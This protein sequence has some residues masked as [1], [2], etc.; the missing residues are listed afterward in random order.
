[1]AT[2][3][4]LYVSARSNGSITIETFTPLLAKGFLLALGLFLAG[5]YIMPHLTKMF[6]ASQELLYMFGL[7]WGFGIASLFHLAGFSIE[8][9]ALFA[10]V[11]LAHLP[12]A[13]EITT[14]LKPLRDFFVFLFF[15]EL[16]QKLG[17]SNIATAIVPAVV[18]S[19]IIMVTKPLLTLVSLGVLGY[20]KQTGF[21]AAVH[22]SQ[23][24]EFS[25]IL[26]VLAHGTGMVDETVTVAITL[27]ALIT[28]IT[29]TYLMN[30]DDQLFRRLRRQLGVFER[31]ETKKELIAGHHY[32]LV[33]LGYK[34]GGHDFIDTFR[35]LTKPYVVIDYD[36][37]V[38]EVLEHQGINHI[39][40]DA[41]DLELLDELGIHTSELIISTIGDSETNRILIRHIRRHNK[42]AVIIC[43]STD[44]EE[45]D[46]LY[47]AGATYVMLPHF[48][49]GEQINSL[50]RQ[51][52]SDRR[53][54]EKYRKHQ[55]EILRK[56]EVR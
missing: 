32:P 54:F 36:P 18:F 30:F 2:L 33:L 48:I 37:N 34:K 53:A 23:I 3:A 22:L 20:T 1:V 13:Q 45:S 47:D 26:A 39:Y 16:G 55:A 27:T 25:I 10:G 28:I 19:L 29:S 31:K 7:A 38:I 11:A 44:Y 43:H 40:G 50:I 56:L 35:K 49:G 14:R 46:G 8:V 15:V 51:H 9:G 21:K 41:A 24:S 52:G 6:A 4:L 12:Y 17:I 42:N 5:R